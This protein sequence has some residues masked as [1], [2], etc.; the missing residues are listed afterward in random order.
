M[1]L[2]SPWAFLLFLLLPVLAYPALNKK[3]S[4]A[5]KF[6]SLVDIKN[7]HLSW[8]LRLRPLLKAARLMCLVLLIV[9]L[10]RPRKGTVISEISTEGVAIEAV[11]DRSGSMQAEMDFGE[12]LNR[13]EV[14]KKVLADFIQGSEKG[15][16]GR[17]SDLIGLITFA[18]YAD[19]VCPLVLS[20]NV[21]L[22]FLKKTEIVQL[23]SEDGTAIGDAIALAAARLKKAEEEIERRNAQLQYSQLEQSDNEEQAGFKIKS[24]AIVLLTDGRNNV[25]EYDPLAAAELAKEWGIKIYTIG[26]G[27]DQAFTTI[28]MM[29]RTYKMPTRQD[30]DEGLLKAIAEKTG[31]FYSR[32]DDVEALRNIVKKIDQLEKTNV[33]SIQYTQYAERYGF[34]TL[35]ALVL[36]TLEILAGCTVFRKIP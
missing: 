27:S 1:Q 23:Q 21:L 15:L 26:I 30:L 9:A 16:T 4:A 29:G 32:A 14:V 7:C 35:S 2:Y 8:R 25:G 13:L 3:N 17:S 6:P 12:K 33:K 20:H 36:L 19:T 10:A 34:L 5:V 24:K 28:D 11:V 18:R 31:G 22:E